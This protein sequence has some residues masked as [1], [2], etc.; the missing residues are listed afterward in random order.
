MKLS[1]DNDAP[2]HEEALN[3]LK[4]DGIYFITADGAAPAEKFKSVTG[5]RPFAMLLVRFGMM[6]EV[7]VGRAIDAASLPLAIKLHGP[8]NP[9]PL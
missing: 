7:N 8:H 9:P 1:D 6:Y 2:R 4:A 5:V 3:A